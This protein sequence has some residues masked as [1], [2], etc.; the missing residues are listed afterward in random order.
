MC[1]RILRR[2]GI[3]AYSNRFTG[4]GGMRREVI[5]EKGSIGK[6][7]AAVGGVI[8]H[9]IRTGV[10]TGGERVNFW[11]FLLSRTKTLNLNRLYD[12]LSPRPRRA[13]RRL[14]GSRIESPRQN[15]RAVL[16]VDLIDQCV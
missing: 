1:K 3:V 2:V 5:N 4:V 9:S 14:V 11:L 10:R 6:R 13:V 15:R 8:D 16:R 12:D 7:G